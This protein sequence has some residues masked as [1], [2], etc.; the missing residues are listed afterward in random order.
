MQYKG[1]IYCIRNKINNKK[2]IGQTYDKQGYKHRWNKHKSDL[3][4]NRHINKKLQSEYN[5]FKSE[6][7]EFYLLDK[8]EFDNKKELLLE[9]DRLEKYYINF[10]QT[11]NDKKGYNINEGGR[12]C[13]RK[14]II[15]I[16][17]GEIFDSTKDV[18]NKMFD[19]NGHFDMISKCCLGKRNSAYRYHF[20]YIE[21]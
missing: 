2:Y 21:E 6:N 20:K 17:T 8:L 15:C 18:I 10:Y 9:L 11:I 4:N 3:K 16:E 5:E 19:G 13:D 12:T 14:K 7:F 1:Y